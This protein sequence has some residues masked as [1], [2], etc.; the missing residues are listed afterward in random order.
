MDE[1]VEVSVSVPQDF[2]ASLRQQYPG[3]LRLSEAL[4]M[5]AEEGCRRRKEQLTPDDI[6]QAI[7]DAIN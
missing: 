6:Q 3:A 1:S 2:A 7:E 5:A 4:R